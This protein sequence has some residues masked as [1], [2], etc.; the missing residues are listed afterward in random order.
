VPDIVGRILVLILAIR[1][2]HKVKK[3]KINFCDLCHLQIIKPTF[4]KHLTIQDLL[5]LKCLVKCKAR[6]MH[7]QLFLI[8][9]DS[10][11]VRLFTVAIINS[12]FCH[13]NA[14]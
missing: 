8:S 11:L 7:T 14:A 4:P 1:V 6:V 9:S 3:A 2:Q 13:K 12:H 5:G 10:Q